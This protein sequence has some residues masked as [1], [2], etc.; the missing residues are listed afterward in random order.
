MYAFCEK[1]GKIIFLPVCFLSHHLLSKEVGLLVLMRYSRKNMFKELFLSAAQPFITHHSSL[2]TSGVAGT[3][4]VNEKSPYLAFRGCQP[5]PFCL[6]AQ[7]GLALQ[8]AGRGPCCAG[9]PNTAQ[10]ER[11]T[12]ASPFHQPVRTEPFSE[13]LTLLSWPLPDTT[14][15]VLGK[16][17]ASCKPVMVCPS[18]AACLR[19]KSC[20]KWK[21]LE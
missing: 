11:R 21:E 2:S 10:P 4:L 20:W 14:P 19:G 15:K 5:A 17:L 1:L 8:A 12:A 6:R 7:A 18:A 13:L 9:L 16:P 3:A